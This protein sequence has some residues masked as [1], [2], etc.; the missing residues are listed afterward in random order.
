MLSPSS[1]LGQSTLL[2]LGDAY[3]QSLAGEGKVTLCVIG[4]RDAN[5]AEFN[6]AANIAVSWRLPVVFVVEN[7]RKVPSARQN[8][9][10]RECHGMPVLSVDGKNVEAVRDS[11]AEAVQRASAGKAPPW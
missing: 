4:D 9:Y 1:T 3:S 8:S 6:A 2:A 7:I 5:S 10:V 11:V